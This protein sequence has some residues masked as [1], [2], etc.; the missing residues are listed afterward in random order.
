MLGFPK[1]TLKV[2]RRDREIETD[3]IFLDAL[4]K[5]KD[6]YYDKMEIAL[7]NRNFRIMSFVFLFIILVFLF[8]SFY[9]QIVQ[10][11]YYSEKA[12]KNK[13]VFKEVEAQRGIIYD[14]NLKQLVS[15]TQSFDLICNLDL[16]FKE[17]GAGEREE[18]EIA[19]ILNLPLSELK[20]MIEKEKDKKEFVVAFDLDKEKVIVFKAR[21]NDF[22]AFYIKKNQEREY[23]S[24]PDFAHILGYVSRADGQGG[25]GIEKYYNEDLKEIAGII[26]TEKDVYGNV[27]KEE[28]K[29]APE[30]GKNVVLNIDMDLQEKAAEIMAPVLRDSGAKSGTVIVMDPNSGAILTMLTLPSY[31]NNIFSKNLSEE[32]YQKILNDPSVS[33]FN[34]AIAGE[35]AIG[36]TVK[37]FIAIEAL[38]EGIITP[39]TTIYCQG[40]IALKDGTFKNDWKA[41]G[42]VNLKK[43][44]A[45]S[46]DVFFYTISGGYG[47]I[48]GLGVEKIDSVL[49]LFGFGKTTEIDLEGETA[50]FVP[51][52]EWKKE[53]TGYGWYPGDT[54]NISIGQGYLKATPLQLAVAYSAIANGGKIVKP[55]LVKSIVDQNNNIIKEF[56]PEVIKEEIVENSFLSAVREGMRETV[57][58]PSGTAHS[59]SY[60]SVTSAAKSGTAET[61]KPNV[62]HNLLTVFAPYEKPEIVISAI[63]ESVPYEKLLV[64]VIVKELLSYYFSRGY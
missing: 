51:T 31:D 27:V 46:C 54:Y 59:L 42:Y 17:E 21:E 26:E 56:A 12:K 40:G 14:R 45:E 4:A 62:Y 22:K 13:F 30:S 32:E 5:K 48:K 6:K 34:R 57:L 3:D 25:A 58:S 23:V 33:F 64:N 15:N 8:V 29:Q 18:V 20:A 35:Y 49:D 47:N 28:M 2:K 60:L 43:A 52:P 53:K 37:P 39:E 63:I 24:G 36:S 61:S 55:Q 9:Y 11:A 1:K 10:G 7:S 44:I 50:G 38:K 16:L 19:N 41:H